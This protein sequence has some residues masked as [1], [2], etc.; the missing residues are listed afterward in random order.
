MAKGVEDTAFYRWNRLVALNEVGGDPGKLG[1][2]PEEF[3]AFAGSLQAEWPAAMTTLSTHDTKRSEDVRARLLA[4][5]EL[6]QEWAVAVREWTE[7]AGRHR[8]P[9][10]WPD[11]A[12]AYLIWQTIVG[13]WSWGGQSGGALAADRLHDCL[14]KAIREGKQHTSWTRPDESYEKA[15][16]AYADAVLDDEDIL[17][18]LA[19]FASALDGPA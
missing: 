5:T 9:E 10:G 7:A 18:A 19:V 4:L 3:H 16:H 6:P 2:P 15:V 8:S 13:T 11:P 17:A 12:T 1:V 14:T